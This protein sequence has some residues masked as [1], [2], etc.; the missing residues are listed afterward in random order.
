MEDKVTRE[1]SLTLDQWE[2][3]KNALEHYRNAACD[4]M[5]YR[6]YLKFDSEFLETVYSQ[7]PDEVF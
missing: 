5:P 3:L 4:F 7:M 1:I 6:D 2:T